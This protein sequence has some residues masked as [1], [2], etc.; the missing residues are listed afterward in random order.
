M[1]P[2]TYKV[3]SSCSWIA[4]FSTKA[5]TMI[6]TD[7]MQYMSGGGIL[8]YSDGL[9]R[10]LLMYVVLWILPRLNPVMDYFTG[11]LQS[12][13]NYRAWE[14]KYLLRCTQS[15]LFGAVHSCW[16]EH[17]VVEQGALCQLAR[18]FSVL[19]SFDIRCCKKQPDYLQEPLLLLNKD[20]HLI[21]LWWNILGCSDVSLIGTPFFS[22]ANWMLEHWT[23]WSNLCSLCFLKKME[24]ISIWMKDWPWQ[25][26]MPG[27]AK[28]R[29]S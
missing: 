16:L 1:Y 23:P 20:G 15:S 22:H 29:F 12:K 25:I 3:I 5:T 17:V 19:G 10:I 6:F 28:N 24:R 18:L 8:I 11:R 4:E 7:G 9:L 27:K 26:I 13:S 14:M 21:I 2:Q